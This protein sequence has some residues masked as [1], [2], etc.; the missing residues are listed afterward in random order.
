MALSSPKLAATQKEQMTQ[1]I[2]PYKKATEPPEGRIR[3][4]EPARAIQVLRFVNTDRRQR[5]QQKLKAYF[6]I[7]NA[8]ASVDKV[9]SLG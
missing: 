3:P 4:I 8:I 7:A 1:K 9:D 6:K 2:N 5:I